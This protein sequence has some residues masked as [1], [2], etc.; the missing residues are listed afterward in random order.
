MAGSVARQVLLGGARVSRWDDFRPEP[1]ATPPRWEKS[2]QK[3]AQPFRLPNKRGTPVWRTRA[4]L[5]DVLEIYRSW[6]RQG[7][8]DREISHKIR[9]T[10]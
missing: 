8:P 7:L 5:M 6:F 3:P 1:Q 4:E 9:T 10:W 2:C